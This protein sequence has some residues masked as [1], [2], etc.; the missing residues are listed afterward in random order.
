MCKAPADTSIK[1]LA[2]TATWGGSPRVCLCP[3]EGS[4]RPLSPCLLPVPRWHTSASTR[5]DLHFHL[6]FDV[7]YSRQLRHSLLDPQSGQSCWGV[8]VPALSHQFAHHAES[9]VYWRGDNMVIETAH[10]WLLF[11]TTEKELPAQKNLSIS[12]ANIITILYELCVSAK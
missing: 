10:M 4:L 2:P 3:E 5:A 9:L 11:Q 1:A 6:I 7:L 8:G 12:L